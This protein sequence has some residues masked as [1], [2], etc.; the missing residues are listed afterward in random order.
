MR[1]RNS[2]TRDTESAVMPLKLPESLLACLSAGIPQ[3]GEEEKLRLRK[4]VRP[5]CLKGGFIPRVYSIDEVQQVNRIWQSRDHVWY[6]G[7][8]VPDIEPSTVDPSKT[9]IFGQIEPESP[10]ALDQRREPNE[11]IY[12]GDINHESCW[13]GLH[14]NLDAFM[15]FVFE[16]NP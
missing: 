1:F 13:I 2:M 10:I 12:F 3:F 16:S 7:G 15:R 8:R 11:V 5:E 4:I 6:L 14:M 9:L